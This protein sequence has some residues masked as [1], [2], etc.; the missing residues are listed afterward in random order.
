MLDH[1]LSAKLRA[2]KDTKLPNQRQ[3]VGDLVTKTMVQE[4]FLKRSKNASMLKVAELATARAAR[5]AHAP[6]QPTAAARPL[7]CGCPLGPRKEP[8]PL[9]CRGEAFLWPTLPKVAPRH[10]LTVFDHVETPPP[11]RRSTRRAPVR[12]SLATWSPR[13]PL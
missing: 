4:A 13:M 1:W 3:T 2:P 5:A 12:R 10:R 9:G 8:R 7:A 11:A 6:Q